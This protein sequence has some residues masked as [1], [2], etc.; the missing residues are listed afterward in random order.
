MPY[1][2]ADVEKILDS[3]GSKTMPIE[4]FGARVKRLREERKLDQ[5]QLASAVGYSQSTISNI[6]RGRNRSSRATIRL[7]AFF[8]VT[9]QYLESGKEGGMPPPPISAQ[10]ATVVDATSGERLPTGPVTRLILE[11]AWVDSNLQLSSAENLRV[12]AMRGDAMAPTIAQGDVL[13]V[14]VGVRTLQADAVLLLSMDGD[15]TCRR[16]QR[17]YD[18]A[19]LICADSAVYPPQELAEGRLRAKVLGR[20]V[21]RLRGQA[22]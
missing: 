5:A 19:W 17:R 13:L 9:P 12:T 4:T 20:V 2:M 1:A 6:E 11:R 14:D 15:V 8:R 18:G 3:P 10:P 22:L 7:A 21:Y 16:V